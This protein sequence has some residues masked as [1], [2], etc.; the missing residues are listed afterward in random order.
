MTRFLYGLAAVAA[1][2]GWFSPTHAANITWQMPVSITTANATLAVDTNVVGAATFGGGPT[3]VITATHPGGI[4]FTADGGGVATVTQTGGEISNTSG[5]SGSGNANFD[6]V[7][8]NFAYDGNPIIVQLQNLSI[9]QTYEIQVFGLDDR[10]CC[11]S[12]T[13]YFSDGNGNNSAIFAEQTNVYVLGTFTANAHTQNVQAVGADQFQSN[14]NA[15]VVNSV[16][17]PASLVLFGVG[18]VGLFAVASRRRAA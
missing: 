5:F 2:G 17:E 14:F 15:V 4:N 12:R 1:L 18:A 7:L 3:T 10:D 16:P 6:S 13:M 9:G 11:G 8:G